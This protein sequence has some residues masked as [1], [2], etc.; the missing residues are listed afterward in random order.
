MISFQLWKE[1]NSLKLSYPVRRNRQSALFTSTVQDSNEQDIFFFSTGHCWHV[2]NG[3]FCWWCS[4]WR[5]VPA[6]LLL[7]SGRYYFVLCAIQIFLDYGNRARVDKCRAAGGGVSPSSREDKG[8]SDEM[9]NRWRSRLSSM[10]S[11][12]P[13][14][15]AQDRTNRLVHAAWSRS[16][17][18]V[19]RQVSLQQWWKCSNPFNIKRIDEIQQ[20]IERCSSRMRSNT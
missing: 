15:T 16:S 7:N 14:R 13:L 20:Q 3:E 18:A 8:A 19:C 11:S 1:N 4:S 6:V 17:P 2:G 10:R 5:R 9:A 12:G